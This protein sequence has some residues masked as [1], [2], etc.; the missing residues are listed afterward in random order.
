MESYP[1]STPYSFTTAWGRQYLRH[2]IT[3]AIF[4]PEY[5]HEYILPTIP[6]R[7]PLPMQP[8]NWEFGVRPDRP[9]DAWSH[10]RQRQQRTDQ[11]VSL[12]RW[13][14]TPVTP[15]QYPTAYYLD[16]AR[17]YEDGPLPEEEPEEEELTWA[18]RG[19]ELI[20]FLSKVLCAIFEITVPLHSVS[21]RMW[22]SVPNDQSWELLASFIV[23]TQVVRVLPKMA[24]V[25]SSSAGGE[26]STSRIRCM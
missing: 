25:L 9:F 18:S 20:A 7:S 8:M 1:P 2:P 24:G 6:E 21:K 23:A 16:Q 15:P 17:F 22:A 11:G 3:G 4:V 10:R 13:P 26:L 5:Y 19:R 14:G 12:P